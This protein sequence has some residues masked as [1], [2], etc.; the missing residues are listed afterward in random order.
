MLFFI[1]PV[2]KIFLPKSAPSAVSK[3]L[4]VSAK[5]IS[6]KELTLGFELHPLCAPKFTHHG[7][8][9]K[10][11]GTL[12]GWT[13]S[14]RSKAQEMTTVHVSC[15]SKNK[16]LW[17]KGH[18]LFSWPY[19][20]SSLKVGWAEGNSPTY[21]QTSSKQDIQHKFSFIQYSLYS[22]M[23]LLHHRTHFPRSCT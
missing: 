18:C 14:L 22:L 1:L 3:H 20:T 17:K 21:W 9:S 16:A 7:E 6:S 2:L 5:V 10:K 8:R 23:P 15:F 11:V 19:K 13:L 12:F 4:E